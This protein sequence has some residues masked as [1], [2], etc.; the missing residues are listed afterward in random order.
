MY[1]FVTYVTS[2]ICVLHLAYCYI[3]YSV[4]KSI[5]WVRRPP[6]FSYFPCRTVSTA[7]AS[8]AR[9]IFLKGV[10]MPP[11]FSCFPCRTVSTT[12]ASVARFIFL[13]GVRTPPV[14]LVSLVSLCRRL[15]RVSPDYYVY[16]KNSTMWKCSVILS[17]YRSWKHCSIN[18]MISIYNFSDCFMK[19]FVFRSWLL[20]YCFSPCIAFQEKL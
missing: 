12:V 1:H 20:W 10:R 2:I 4:P 6:C 13:K 3:Y 9:F 16:S 11:S 7:V 15:S 14:F 8:V 18:F 17:P 5:K 19:L